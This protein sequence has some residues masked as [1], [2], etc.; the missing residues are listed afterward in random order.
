M[1]T[2]WGAEVPRLSPTCAKILLE[3]SAKAAWEYHRLGG[4][5]ESEDSDA[6]ERGRIMDR[7]LLG[8][9]PEIVVCRVVKADGQPATDWKTKAA[10]EF[11]DAVAAD[12]KIP[13]MAAKLAGYEKIISA[14][15]T[16]L[17]AQGIELS[18]QSQ[19]KVDWE[20]DGVPCRGKLDHL[21]IA[22]DAASAVIIDL[23]SVDVASDG[24]TDRVVVTYDYAT[25][26]AAYVEGIETNWPDAA[27][28]VEFKLAFCETS[29]PYD[30]N[31]RPLGGEAKEYGERRWRRAKRLWGECLRTGV[32]PGYAGGNPVKVSA[33][34][35]AEEMDT[36]MGTNPGVDF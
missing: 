8:V 21:I 22:P 6:K 1:T 25:Q 34:K 23:K 16:A 15:K 36:D 35:L 3:R 19:V 32:F 17:K 33:F 27:G 18:G 20:S 12:G 2:P 13:I 29:A 31:V 11:R 4:A 24:A 14:W 10:Q 30:V 28:R 7:L 9:G 26:V 5:A